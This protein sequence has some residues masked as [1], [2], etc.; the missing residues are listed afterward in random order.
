MHVWLHEHAYALHIYFAVCYW[1]IAC[2][3]VI[4]LQ[5]NIDLFLF[6]KV[7]LELN[8]QC[9]CRFYP[10]TADAL[11]LSSSETYIVTTKQ[12]YLLQSYIVLLCDLT[13]RDFHVFKGSVSVLCTCL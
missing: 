10:G 5:V 4:V 9:D 1:L 11:K 3:C 7:L 2:V 12:V 13:F 8:D 6:V